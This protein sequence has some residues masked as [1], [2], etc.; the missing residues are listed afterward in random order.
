[1]DELKKAF[2]GGEQGTREVA[3]DIDGH[4]LSDDIGNIGDQARHDLGNLGDDVRGGAD[5][6]GADRTFPETEPSDKTF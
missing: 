5:R 1:M 2:R 3:R 4:D 6:G